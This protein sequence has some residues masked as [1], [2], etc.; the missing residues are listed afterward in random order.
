MQVA[1]FP[2]LDEHTADVAA[3]P[4]DVWPA[5]LETLDRAFSGPVVGGYARIVGCADTTASGP[6]PLAE[7]ARLPGFRV[8]V[9]EPGRALVLEGSHRFSAYALSFRLEA[10][11][12]GSTRLR[13]ESRA[14]FPGLAGQGYRLLVVGTGAHVLAVRRLLLAVRRRSE[15]RP[16]RS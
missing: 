2:L 5:L 6:R 15:P 7:G 12:A 9:A 13:A 4:D 3:A 11:G 8:A 1:P 10:L 16:A 14:T